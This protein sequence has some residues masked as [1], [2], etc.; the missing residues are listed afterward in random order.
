MEREA[1]KS[2]AKP[3]CT[4]TLPRGEAIRSP[5]PPRRHPPLD[6]C[7]H[8][9]RVALPA[10]ACIPIP[11]PYD[12]ILHIAPSA[13]SSHPAHSPDCPSG[14]GLHFHPIP[15]DVILHAAVQVPALSHPPRLRISKVAGKQIRTGNPP[16]LYG[17]CFLSRL[18]PQGLFSCT[19]CTLKC[20]VL[21]L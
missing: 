11:I 16:L 6:A 19:E 13:S 18:V 21:E 20:H 15:H 7:P 9:L 17:T 1:R 2:P 5:V 12:V 14:L 3:V 8:T 10:S 4:T